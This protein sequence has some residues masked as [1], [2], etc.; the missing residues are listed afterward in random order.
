MSLK[1]YFV[2]DIKHLFYI[3]FCDFKFCGLG[4][5]AEIRLPQKLSVI[6]YVKLCLQ[7]KECI[8]HSCHFFGFRSFSGFTEESKTIDIIYGKLCPSVMAILEFILDFVNDINQSFM[9]SLGFNLLCCFYKDI[10]T[11][12]IVFYVKLCPAVESKHSLYHTF[13]CIFVT[14]RMLKYFFF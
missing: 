4:L 7:L 1:R 11:Y 9:F 13:E 2:P 3:I 14:K 8:A 12:H 5:T 6:R 10:F